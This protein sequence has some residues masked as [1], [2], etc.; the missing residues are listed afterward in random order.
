MITFFVGSPGLPGGRT[1]RVSVFRR[2]FRRISFLLLR[3]L[4]RL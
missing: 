4:R 3:K 1:V 2:I